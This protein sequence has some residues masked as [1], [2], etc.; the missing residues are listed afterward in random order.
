[1]YRETNGQP[2]RE[3]IL[4]IADKLMLSENNVYKWFWD[5]KKNN[6]KATVSKP[7]NNKNDIQTTAV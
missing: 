2:N 1:M 4:V 5:T 6:S 7:S 3:Q